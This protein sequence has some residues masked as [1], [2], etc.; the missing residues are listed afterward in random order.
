MKISTKLSFI[1]LIVLIPILA[2]GQI[3]ETQTQMN[4]NRLKESGETKF[5]LAGYGFSGFEQEGDESTFGPLGFSPIF[6][7]KKTDRLFFE[8]ELEA[9]IED[10]EFDVGLEYASIYYRLNPYLIFGAG[11]FLTPFGIFGERLHPAWINKMAEKPLGFS[12]E[13]GMVGPM[14]S[15]GAQLRGGAPVGNAKVNYSFYLSNGPILITDEE[16]EAG[17]LEFENFG[18][19]NKNKAVGGRIGFLPLANSTLEIGASA[20]FA[21]VGDADSPYEDISANMYSGDISYIWN[22]EALKSLVDFRGQYNHQKVDRATYFDQQDDAF[23]FDNNSTAY[24]L[25]LAL[26]PVNVDSDILKNLELTG[27]YSRLSTPEGSPWYRK[28]KET[29]IGLNYWLSWSSVL[30]IN[31]AIENI[32]GEDDENAL[33]IQFSLGF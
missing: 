2:S 24:F 3:N 22:L 15:L 16:D 8:A 4:E 13:G 25:Q 1:T 7:W 9:E 20:Q 11:K 29:T 21:K 5:L 10:G 31:Y 28:Q 32:K 19:N 23:T 17:M 27:R 30:K 12:E 18:D 33:F 6:L 14:T 26:R